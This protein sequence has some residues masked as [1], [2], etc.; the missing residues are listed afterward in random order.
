M[1]A[2]ADEQGLIR[3]YVPY[4]RDEV[5]AT[6]GIMLQERF[7]IKQKHLGR[8]LT[9]QQIGRVKYGE[10]EAR[11]NVKVTQEFG[12]S[13][14]NA[15]ELVQCALN[16]QVPTVRDRDPLTD[17]YFVNPDE[18]L[19]ARYAR[20]AFVAVRDFSATT[21]AS[22]SMS[23]LAP[24]FASA[25]AYPICS[26]KPEIVS[27][28]RSFIWQPNATTLAFLCSTCIPKPPECR[29]YTPAASAPTSI[30]MTCA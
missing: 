9:V 17:K 4:R 1:D 18:T 25:P 27:A 13:R 11:Q 5:Q 22:A 2:K 8:T 23:A 24:P 20:E 3:R 7:R 21:M 12:T 19:A 30:S 29:V 15:I 16:V 14:M 28:S 26:S 10:W 6:P